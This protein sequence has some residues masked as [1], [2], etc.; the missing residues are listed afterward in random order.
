MSRLS[1]L[2]HWLRRAAR[3][4]PPGDL[5][6]ITMPHRALS[7]LL[8]YGLHVHG[9]TRVALRARMTDDLDARDPELVDVTLS[10]ARAFGRYWFRAEI[11]GVLTGLLGAPV[12]VA[13][14]TTDGLGLTGEGRGIGAIATALLERR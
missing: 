12:A 2:L 5:L 10:L 3:I 14:T 11:E 6:R 9:K 8:A 1:P 13:A 4:A 7:M